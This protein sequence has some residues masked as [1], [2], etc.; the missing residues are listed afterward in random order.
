MN[1]QKDHYITLF[2]GAL[3]TLNFAAVALLCVFIHVTN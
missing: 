1:D 3:L 2:Q